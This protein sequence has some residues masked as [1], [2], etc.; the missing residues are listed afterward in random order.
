MLKIRS[1][2]IEAFQPVAD[3]Q[4]VRR[5]IEHLRTRHEKV[6]VR[7]ESGP[8]LIGRLSAG[9][10]QQMVQQGVTQAKAYGF[11]WES[12]IT[13]FVVLM[14]KV[15]PNFDRHPAINRALS[16]ATVSPDARVQRLLEVTSSSD[17]WEAKELYDPAAWQIKS[18]GAAQ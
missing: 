13:A 1:E 15:S 12:S 9:L 18:R 4:F 17:W 8:I 14:F 16:E 11:T 7:L 3:A 6:V 5:I 2:Q 10:L